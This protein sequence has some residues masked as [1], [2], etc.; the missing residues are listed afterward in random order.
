MNA[1][2]V[3]FYLIRDEKTGGYADSDRSFLGGTDTLVRFVSEKNARARILEMQTRGVDVSS[4]VIVPIQAQPLKPIQPKLRKAKGG[5]VIKITHP[6]DYSIFWRGNKKNVSFDYNAFVYGPAS[7]A[8]ASVF[9][10]EAAAWDAVYILQREGLAWA[11]RAK[12]RWN[13]AQYEKQMKS[14]IWEVVKT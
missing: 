2:R 8:T 10:S 14:A 9:P 7:P 11:E 13:G 6:K 4:V 12:G 5:Y 3:D 1:D